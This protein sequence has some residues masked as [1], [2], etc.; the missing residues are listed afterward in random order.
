MN[1]RVLKRTYPSEFSYDYTVA[2]L[3]KVFHTNIFKKINVCK[4]SLAL[5]SAPLKRF[6]IINNDHEC[7]YGS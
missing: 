6:L 4:M 5:E 7:F 3:S 2:K 1:S